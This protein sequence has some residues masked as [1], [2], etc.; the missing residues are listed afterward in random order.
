MLLTGS[1]P[2]I[3]GPSYSRPAAI[4]GIRFV[5]EY[6]SFCGCT[7][8][9]AWSRYTSADPPQCIA[10]QQSAAASPCSLPYFDRATPAWQTSCRQN[11]DLEVIGFT[12]GV[13]THGV[14]E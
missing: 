6:G 13:R 3:Q 11:N 7:W 9:M 4:I 1:K 2:G 10:A 14:Q 8:K 5:S 12:A